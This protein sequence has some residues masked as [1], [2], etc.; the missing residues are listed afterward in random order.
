[1][2]EYILLEDD[3]EVFGRG[4]EEGE[5][6]FWP[7]DPAYPYTIVR[8]GSFYIRLGNGPYEA[9]LVEILAPSQADPDWV[10]ERIT[11]GG[12][13]TKRDQDEAWEHLKKDNLEKVRLAAQ[14]YAE[15]RS[16]MA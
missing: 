16:E 6:R 1:M 4:G 10:T 13:A 2:E 7:N 12:H 14:F 5:V 8:L 11:I 15:K 9:P 3:V